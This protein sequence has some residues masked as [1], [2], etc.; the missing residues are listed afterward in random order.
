[1]TKVVTD[2]ARADYHRRRIPR[3]LQGIVIEGFR[4]TPVFNVP[5]R[6][7][8][9]RAK[10]V[11]FTEDLIE[12]ARARANYRLTDENAWELATAIC[13]AHEA[14][15]REGLSELDK[16]EVGGLHAGRPDA[17]GWLRRMNRTFSIDDTAKVGQWVKRVYDQRFRIGLV[18][19]MVGLD[20]PE[21]LTGQAP[22]V[23]NQTPT[24]RVKSVRSVAGKTPLHSDVAR[25]YFAL[26]TR[27]ANYRRAL[28]QFREQCGDLEIGAYT[29]DHVWAFR[30]WLNETRDEKKG[31]LLA[32]KTKNNKMSAISSLFG[33]SIEKRYRNDN[34]TRDVKLFPKTENVK[35]R[36]RLYTKDELTAVFIKGKPELEW[37]KWSP[38]LG[39]YAGVRITE[40]IQLKPGDVSNEFGVWHLLIQPGRGQKV[41]GDR[42]RVIPVHEELIRLGFIDYAKAAKGAKREW[43]FPDVPLVEKKGKDYNAPDVETIMVPS[44]NAATQWF[45]RYSDECGVS[46]PNVD[47]HAIRGNF[48]TYGAQL[49]KSLSLRMELAGHSTGSGVHQTYIYA[50]SSL[51]SLK[52]EIDKVKYPIRIPR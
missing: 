5:L 51:K 18:Q 9:T 19:S 21:A 28:E 1:L 6:N 43:L 36:R 4:L 16:L 27:P 52:A 15:L 8:M 3:D 13:D 30:N 45:G 24:D 20:D 17:R 49:G 32:G 14:L 50:G 33:F 46:D 40:S 37:Q 38:R 7:G 22:V 11:A 42:A 48:V 25:E 26:K 41:K 39:L 2:V 34:P 31:E 44:Q 10:A 35:K 23:R 12:K 29:Q 47:F